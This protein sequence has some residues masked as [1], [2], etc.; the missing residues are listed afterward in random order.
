MQLNGPMKV[1]YQAGEWLI[2]LVYANLLWLI[3]IIVG[4]GIFGLMPATV[5]LFTLLRQ[6]IMGNETESAF[7]IYWNSFRQEF[8]KSNLFG[9]IFLAIGYILRI[10]VIFFK[11]SSHIL[12]QILLVMMFCLSFLYLITLLNFFPVY[13]HF[14]I[15]F[16]EYFKYALLIGISQLSSTIMMM[17][18]CVVIICLYWYFSG[19]IPLLCM[20]LFSLNLMWFGFRSFK[21]IEYEQQT[22]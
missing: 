6:W 16:F 7:K 13:V 8:I 3:F 15:S 9:L 17:I 22:Q 2:K 5:G 4:L 12:F 11:T 20:S 21:K 14:K 1:V 18:G 10:D 19:L